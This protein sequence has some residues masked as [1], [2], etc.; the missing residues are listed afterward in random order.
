[1][2]F[3]RPFLL[4]TTAGQ[5][6]QKVTS[7]VGAWI[8]TMTFERGGAWTRARVA[9]GPPTVTLVNLS[10]RPGPAPSGARVSVRH[11]AR[12]SVREERKTVNSGW[13]A[14]SWLRVEWNGTRT[15]NSPPA[16][17]AFA[18]VEI[19]LLRS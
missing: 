18:C 19:V 12:G 8:G 14:R 9:K 4:F 13:R 16:I 6:A 3:I 5:P 1:M 7:V 17:L 15:D 10:G 11:R 2:L